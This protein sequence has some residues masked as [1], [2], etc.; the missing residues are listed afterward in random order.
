MRWGPFMKIL[1]FIDG[2][3]H[4]FN[5]VK[6]AAQIAKGIG[7]LVTIVG[8]APRYI[9]SEGIKSYKGEIKRETS[10]ILEKAKK[11][12]DELGVQTRVEILED[13]SLFNAF[14]EIISFIKERGFDLLIIGSPSLSG[15]KKFFHRG[16]GRDLG[17]SLI[18]KAPCSV[19]VVRS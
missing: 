2:S 6:T 12:M 15:L 5:A 9:D 11:M 18:N 3:E 19:L 8:I 7:S 16:I 14:N 13:M 10:L 1:V 4:S 17:T